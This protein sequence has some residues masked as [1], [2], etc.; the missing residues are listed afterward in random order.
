MQTIRFEINFHFCFRSRSRTSHFSFSIL[1]SS[2]ILGS[3]FDTQLLSPI[4]TPVSP[5]PLPDELWPSCAAC[6]HPHHSAPPVWHPAHHSSPIKA[7]STVCIAGTRKVLHAAFCLSS[8]RVGLR[9]SHTALP[10]DRCD[11]IMHSGKEFESW[12]P[13][14]GTENGSESARLTGLV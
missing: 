14:V 2:S 11:F 10:A 13:Q 7:R 1:F 3:N 6:T 5:D 8:R 4:F 12:A 9:P